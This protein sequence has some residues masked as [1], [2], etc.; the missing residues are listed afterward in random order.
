MQP[1]TSSALNIEQSQCLPHLLLLLAIGTL[2]GRRLFARHV[3]PPRLVV[4]AAPVIVTGICRRG[5]RAFPGWG[6][7]SYC[8]VC[9]IHL[10]KHVIRNKVGGG[11]GRRP[12]SLFWPGS[13]VQLCVCVFDSFHRKND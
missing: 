1:Q 13:A 9:L 2:S 5:C 12:L 3:C 7:P 4:I 8:C 10:K 6:L 11:G